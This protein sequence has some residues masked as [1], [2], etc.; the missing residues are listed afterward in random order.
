MTFF[1]LAFIALLI[2]SL[3]F[4]IVWL[5]LFYYWHEKRETYIVVP[6]LFTF[7]FFVTGFL[8]IS[9]LSIMV[10]YFFNLTVLIR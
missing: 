9:L 5:S 7:E 6:M 2:A 3:I 4:Y 10:N 8:F 1:I